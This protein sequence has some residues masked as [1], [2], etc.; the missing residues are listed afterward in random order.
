MH[1][2]RR[3]WALKLWVDSFLVVSGAVVLGNTVDKCARMSGSAC[4]GVI[5]WIITAGLVSMVWFGLLA[6]LLSLTGKV[7]PIPQTI[8]WLV[9]VFFVAWWAA[10]VATVSTVTYTGR[11]DELQVAF[12]FVSLVLALA[13][14]AMSMLDS[15]AVGEIE[16]RA[17]TTEVYSE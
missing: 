7:Y 3:L 14:S 5:G 2:S 9:N 13:A 1:T 11:F 6:L 8:E 4:D 10:A 17:K 15:E 16:P 12:S